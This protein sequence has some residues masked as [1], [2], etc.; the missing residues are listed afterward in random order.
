MACQ[1]HLDDVLADYVDGLLTGQQEHQVERHLVACT[2]CRAQVE[3]ERELMARMRDVSLDAGQHQQLMAGLLSL[4]G[5]QPRTSAQP[6]RPAPALVTAGAPA[7]YCS[8]RRSV[9]FTLAAV[10]GLVGAAL[11]VAA[12][13]GAGHG[14]AHPAGS[15]LVHLEV[16]SA[17]LPAIH[18]GYPAAYTS[19]PIATI[20]QDGAGH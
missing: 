15:P 8:A 11:T 2:C 20:D 14:E 3:A 13:P 6:C 7:Q 5:D 17:H 18:D 12:V 10:A 19:V 9:A 4:A 16:V 1:A